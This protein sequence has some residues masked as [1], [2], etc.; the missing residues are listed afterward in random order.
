MD[1]RTELMDDIK[2]I[3]LLSFTSP[4]LCVLCVYFCHIAGSTAAF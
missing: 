1:Y 3:F 4:L 2:L